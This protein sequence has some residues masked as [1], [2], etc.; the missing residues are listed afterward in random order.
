MCHKCKNANITVKNDGPPNNGPTAINYGFKT[1][2]TKVIHD[3]IA[4]IHF[5]SM[6]KTWQGFAIS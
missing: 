3:I 2:F 4:V 1:I 5:H 6:K